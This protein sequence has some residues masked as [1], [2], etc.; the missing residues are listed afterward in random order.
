VDRLEIFQDLGRAA[1]AIGRVLGE[2]ALDEHPK[3][4]RDVVVQR[5]GALVLHPREQRDDV[6]GDDGRPTGQ[7]LVEDERIPG[8]FS[9]SIPFLRNVVG[10]IDGDFGPAFQYQAVL[11][12]LS[13]N[14]PNP[15]VREDARHKLAWIGPSADGGLRIVSAVYGKHGKSV[16]V[17]TR[18]NKAI[19]DGRLRITA[20]N[21]ISGDPFHG[22]QKDLRVEYRYRGKL[23]VRTVHEGH[24]LALP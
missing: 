16:D 18:L 20:S 15:W 3:T 14:H 5:G 23:Y 21:E 22:T 6:V 12:G 8:D 11:L 19:S 24:T 9:T 13:A 2:Q 7:H 4:R 1:G 17:T 10:R